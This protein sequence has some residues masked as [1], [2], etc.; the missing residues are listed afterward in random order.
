[1]KNS[2]LVKI[3]E[4]HTNRLLISTCISFVVLIAL[5]LINKAQNSGFYIESRI[6]A[7]TISIIF[8]AISVAVAVVCIVKKKL[9]LIEYIAFALVMSFCFY[10]V[11]GVGFVNAKIMKYITGI[12]DA[13]Y[14]VGAYLYHTFAPKLLKK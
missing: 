13:A 1:M 10:G 6:A 14:L 3:T 2:E 5:L 12:V 9:H 8:L 7:L 11:H 4:K